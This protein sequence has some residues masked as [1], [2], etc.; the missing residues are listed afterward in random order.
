MRC[1]IWSALAR[2]RVGLVPDEVLELDL[3]VAEIFFD[4]SKKR[5]I[6]I[7]ARVPLSS[8]MLSRKMTT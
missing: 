3:H 6:G 5:E 8:G 2:G 1:A 7:L 4:M